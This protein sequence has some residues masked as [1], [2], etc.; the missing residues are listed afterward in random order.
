VSIDPV[1]RERTLTLR[2]TPD[3][4]E[5]DL[6]DHLVSQLVNRRKIDP[7][8]SSKDNLNTSHDG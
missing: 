5:T 7:K 2:F 8:E 4:Q 1:T 3:R 6:V